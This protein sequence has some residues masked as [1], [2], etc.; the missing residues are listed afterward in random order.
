[1][2]LVSFRREQFFSCKSCLAR[3]LV[4]KPYALFSSLT[5][6]SLQLLLFISVSADQPLISFRD[7][8]D[9]IGAMGTW[10]FLKSLAKK[11][12]FLASASET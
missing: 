6:N 5:H 10:F 2:P 12:R 7:P 9:L 8:C 11:A 4:L 3:I 1:M